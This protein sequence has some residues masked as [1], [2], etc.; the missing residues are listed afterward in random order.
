[1]ADLE[2]RCK[3]IFRC[4]EMALTEVEAENVK[5]KRQ[6]EPLKQ[7]ITALEKEIEHWKEKEDALLC[8][9]ERKSAFIE[10]QERTKALL[11]VELDQRKAMIGRLEKKNEE[12]GYENA[13]LNIQL[14]K[15]E[16]EIPRL[17][18][19]SLYDEDVD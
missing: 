13:R 6:V 1:M 11:L 5:L 18:T 2:E 9:V 4:P 10:E 19:H 15:L 7:K 14:Y 3:R 12:L 16:D 8:Q 17:K